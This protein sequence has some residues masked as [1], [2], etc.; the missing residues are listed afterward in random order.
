MGKS[1]HILRISLCPQGLLKVR[2]RFFKTTGQFVIRSGEACEYEVFVGFV[3]QM[4][5][6]FS[7]FLV[8][9]PFFM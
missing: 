6:V 3:A 1:K 7:R 9:T 8:Q 2:C 4:L 5:L